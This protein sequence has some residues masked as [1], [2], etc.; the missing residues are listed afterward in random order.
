MRVC[1]P[2]SLSQ[3]A[4]L[5]STAPGKHV[6]DECGSVHTGSPQAPSPPR[7]GPPAPAEAATLA[8][9]GPPRQAGCEFPWRCRCFKDEL[10]K[11]VLEAGW[12]GCS[13][14]GEMTRELHRGG[15]P[16]VA[17]D[18]LC[19]HSSSGPFR[20]AHTPPLTSR[21]GSPGSPSAAISP[22]R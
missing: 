17:A 4:H 1:C 14:T 16:C 18:L 8:A 5:V 9:R 21:T 2:V 15:G 3:S 19:C 11:R 6:S 10:R 13:A 12:D 7:H 20:R 22:R